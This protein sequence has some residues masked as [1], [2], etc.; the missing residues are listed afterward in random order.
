MLNAYL[1][2]F[3]MARPHRGLGL[4]VPM[5]VHGRA[6]AVDVEAPIE[7]LDVL[8]GLIHEYCRAA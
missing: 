4:D 2:H 6:G 8:G 3:N 7:R 5:P 1:A